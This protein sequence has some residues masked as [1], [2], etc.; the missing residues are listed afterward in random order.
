MHVSTDPLAAQRKVP[1]PEL[2]HALLELFSRHRLARHRRLL[3]AFHRHDRESTGTLSLSEFTHTIQAEYPVLPEVAIPKV[4]ARHSLSGRA[5][6]SLRGYLDACRDVDQMLMYT[7]SAESELTSLVSGHLQHLQTRI[8]R[9]TERGTVPSRVLAPLSGLSISVRDALGANRPGDAY[10]ALRELIM[11]LAAAERQGGENTAS[12][13][14]GHGR[15]D[16]DD[17]GN[18]YRDEL[19]A[20]M[21]LLRSDG[22]MERERE[23]ERER[24][25]S[26]A[27]DAPSH[28]SQSRQGHAHTGHGLM[29]TVTKE[30]SQDMMPPT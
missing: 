9:L 7:D 18:M 13:E 6:V 17:R 15:A 21:M 12:N 23:R 24:D 14:D 4:F 25:A 10:R 19:G 1:V 29:L 28:G 26:P 27:K 30:P 22:D 3:I 20:L 5:A 11:L 16:K 8:Q 2:L